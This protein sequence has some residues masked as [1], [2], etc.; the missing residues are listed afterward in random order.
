[1]I[2]GGASSGVCRCDVGPAVDAEKDLL[3][4]RQMSFT[5]HDGEEPVRL[6]RDRRL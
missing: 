5:R 1:M 6:V 4:G 3:A 2:A